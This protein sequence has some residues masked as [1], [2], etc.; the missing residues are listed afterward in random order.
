[1]L[2]KWNDILVNA[3]WTHKEDGFF[4]IWINGKLTYEHKGKTHLKGD[5][6]EY[7]LGIYRSFG[8]RSPGADPT[9]IVYFDELRYAKSCKKLKLKD[10]GYSCKEI[11]NQN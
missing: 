6:I 3:K 11:E 8:S 9:Q 5:E 7:Q 4:K 10:L 1:M 2:G